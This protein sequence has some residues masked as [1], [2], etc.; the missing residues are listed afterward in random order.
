MI[1][2]VNFP[3]KQLERRSLKKSRLQRDSN[4]WPPRYRRDAL[5]SY[6]ATHWERGQFIHS[7]SIALVLLRSW[8]RIPLKPWFFS[9]F[10]FPIA[11]IGKFTAVVILHFDLQLQFKYMNYFVYT[12]HHFTPH[13]ITNSINLPRSQYVASYCSSVGRASHQYREGHGFESHWTEALIFSGFF[14]PIA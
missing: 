12:S 9:D 11:K 13:G 8:V 7:L 5:L 14:F 1:I 2:A 6:E 3:T 10:F 4:P